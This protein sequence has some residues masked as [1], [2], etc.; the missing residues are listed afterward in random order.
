MDVGDTVLVTTAEGTEAK[1][2]VAADPETLSATV[3]DASLSAQQQLGKAFAAQVAPRIKYLDD[4]SLA[5][6][7]AQTF[8]T[9]YAIV[10]IDSRWDD[11]VPKLAVPMLRKLEIQPKGV[12]T[13]EERAEAEA[14]PAAA[15]EGEA[16]PAAPATL[17]KPT[18]ALPR[19]KGETA[20]AYQQRC[21]RYTLKQRQDAEAALKRVPF[22]LA[23]F[24][25][26]MRSALENEQEARKAE[27]AAADKL[28]AENK[29]QYATSTP[30]TEVTTTPPQANADANGQSELSPASDAR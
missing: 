15:A 19:R 13:D 28:T 25:D 11:L 24:L 16:A 18:G 27:R 9:D 17:R 4:N 21:N 1:T 12:A 5:Q 14:A 22:M 20:K 6:V 30:G 2:I 26:I 29:E 10:E 23:T 3:K 8:V 7:Y